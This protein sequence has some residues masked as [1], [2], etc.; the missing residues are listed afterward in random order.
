MMVS[1]SLAV[2]ADEVPIQPTVEEIL[3][4]YHQ[5]AFEAL[6]MEDTATISTI[7]PRGVNSKTLEQ[8][9]VDTL[10]EAGY[11]A[12]NVTADNYTSLEEELKTDFSAMG[13]D[14]DSSYIFVISGEDSAPSD[15]G[16][17]ASLYNINPLPGWDQ[18]DVGDNT[19]YFYY[20]YEGT[21]YFMR[22]VTVTNA[23]T[24]DELFVSTSHVLSDIDRFEDIA[25]VLIE[26]SISFAAE[27][28]S[29]GGVICSVISLLGDVYDAATQSCISTLDPG[30]INLRAGTAWT[31]SYIQVY[32]EANGYWYT[33][34]CSSYAISEVFFLGDYVYDEDTN[35]PVLMG[36]V[37]HEGTIYSPYYNQTEV[38]KARAVYGYLNNNP[39][40][41]HTGDIDFY[42]TNP[43][44][45]N[46]DISTIPLFIH[47]QNVTYRYPMI[48]ED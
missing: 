34:Q 39:L 38:R 43:D 37:I 17:S 21:T 35:R 4:E 29:N 12:Y 11:E 16:D 24:S 14:S 47:K 31:R 10:M 36:G 5:E 7:S 44:S 19:P 18:P 13:L 46:P 23:D 2:A 1:L 22:Y 48:Q 33:T 9:T 28:I 20:T 15:T 40:F 25:A 6:N 32:N 8:K 45:S 26:Y 3:N 27:A 42:F 41:D 30:T